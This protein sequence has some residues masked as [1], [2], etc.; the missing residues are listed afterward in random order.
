MPTPG[1]AFNY[2]LPTLKLQ[3]PP[4]DIYPLPIEGKRGR[5]GET[6]Q[7]LIQMDPDGAQSTEATTTSAL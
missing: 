3:L 1:S 6:E 2:P 5:E 4:P 7:Q